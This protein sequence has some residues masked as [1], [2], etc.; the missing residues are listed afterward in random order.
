M[1]KENKIL[2]SEIKEFEKYCIDFYD[3]KCGIYPIATAK[4]IKEAI[5]VFLMLYDLS[6]IDFDSLDRERV[7]T[8]LNK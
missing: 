5:K 6:T 1:T 2:I 3:I 8:I 7:R 4:E